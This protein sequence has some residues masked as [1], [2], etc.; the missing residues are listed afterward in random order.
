MYEYWADRESTAGNHTLKYWALVAVAVLRLLG[1][2]K[3]SVR[4]LDG[5]F[6]LSLASAPVNEVGWH[7]YRS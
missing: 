3:T 5:P 2:S 1:W 4:E 6:D 7:C